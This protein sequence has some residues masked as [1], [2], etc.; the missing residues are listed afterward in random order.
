MAALLLLSMWLVK[1]VKGSREV[2]I[3]DSF[4]HIP[5]LCQCLGLLSAIF[6]GP[7]PCESRVHC[8]C[9]VNQMDVDVHRAENSR[10]I[11]TLRKHQLT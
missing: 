7:F 5:C 9:I 8:V 3:T 11:P 1:K 10:P 6:V 2:T 4:G